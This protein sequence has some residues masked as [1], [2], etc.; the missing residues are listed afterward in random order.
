VG[1]QS[2]L[3]RIIGFERYRR[4]KDLEETKLPEEKE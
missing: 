4:A 3:D 2:T 1:K